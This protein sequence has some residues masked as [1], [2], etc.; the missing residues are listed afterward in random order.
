[1]IAQPP[2]E[3]FAPESEPES[4]D[5]SL[6][7]KLGFIVAGGVISAVTSSLPPALR[8]GAELSAGRAFERWLVLSALALPLS[9]FA[10]AVLQRARVGVRLLAGESTSLLAT[11]ILWWCVIE[12]GVLSFFGA[13]LRK[14]THHHALAGVT[15]AVFAVVSGIFVA[16]FARRTTLMLAR[17]SATLQRAA[18][19]V[20]GASAFA[21]IMLVGFRTSRADGM[22]TAAMLVDGVALAVTSTIVSSR[23]FSHWRPLALASVP[24]AVLVLVAGLTKLRF[25]PELGQSLLETAPIHAWV[26]TLLGS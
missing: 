15:F 5:S 23:A 2:T 24:A 1:M 6:A 22:H 25:S 18:F 20:A 13:L 10:V 21:G 16:L 17:G 8:I 12:L 19:A 9:V 26:L 7:L 11:G 3:R 4:D 14:A